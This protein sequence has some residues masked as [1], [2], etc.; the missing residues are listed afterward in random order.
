MR[1]DILKLLIL[2]GIVLV[3]SVLPLFV[4][5]FFIT[6]IIRIIYYGLLAVAFSFLAGQLGLFS[7][8][9]PVSF[10]ISG[11]AI[12][13]FETKNILYFPYSALMGILL[14]LILSAF[15]GIL[16][17]R[18]KGTYFLMLT[19]VLGQVVWAI[20][21]QWVSLTKGTTGITSI[22]RPAFLAKLSENSNV[23]F[24]YLALVVFLICIVG[25]YAL[26]NSSF[27]MK[28]RGIRESE[29]RMI[30]LGYNVSLIKWIAFMISSFI[31]SISG[32]LFVYFVRLINPDSIG[33]TAAVNVMI[34]SIFGGI[35][36][37]FGAILGTGIIKTFE[38]VLSGITQRYLLIIGIMFL[39]VIIFIPKGIISIIE[40]IRKFI[41][42]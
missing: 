36:S 18:S 10:A 17:N 34:A 28:L 41:K 24:Y 3:L 5:Q 30:M 13:I 1:K 9:V 19:L 27:G 26:I 37:I 38:I 7:L 42:K 11:Y 4:S 29:S 12:A 35:N 31:S 2:V 6:M 32:V 20:S 23:S 14:A 21:L 8:M 25:L 39:L 15:F 40:Q 22:N 33:L 16:V